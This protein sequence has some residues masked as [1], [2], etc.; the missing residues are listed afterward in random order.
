MERAIYGNRCQ[1]LASCR[2]RKLKQMIDQTR[3]YGIYSNSEL[4]STSL[5]KPSSTMVYCVELWPSNH[6]ARLG[7]F[8]V[9]FG[10]ESGH[11]VV[12]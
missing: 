5:R 3:E 12:F 6:I 4:L 11:L 2:W 8:F 7:G 10:L 1:G 9:L